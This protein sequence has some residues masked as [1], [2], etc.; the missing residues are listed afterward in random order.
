VSTEAARFDPSKAVNLAD[1]F[2]ESASGWK[3]SE[4]FPGWKIKSRVMDDD[5]LAVAI[6]DGQAGGHRELV[7]TP[8]GVAVEGAIEGLKLMIERRQRILRWQ[9]EARREQ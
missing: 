8:D 4:L 3:D 9:Q 5:S 1:V 6:W 2:A 7:K